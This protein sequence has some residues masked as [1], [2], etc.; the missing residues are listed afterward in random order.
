MEIEFGKIINEL[1]LKE[2]D[3]EMLFKSAIKSV[4]LKWLLEI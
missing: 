2:K 1:S 3:K 4:E